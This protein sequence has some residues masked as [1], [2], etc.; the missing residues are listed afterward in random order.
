MLIPPAFGLQGVVHETY[1]GDGSISYWNRYVGVSQM[2]GQGNFSDP[3]IGLTI[4]QKPDR[5]ASRLP[6]LLGKQSALPLHLP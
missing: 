1:T 2:G 4:L 6:A 5:V 3:R